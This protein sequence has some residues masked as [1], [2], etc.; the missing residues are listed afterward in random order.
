MS[1]LWDVSVIGKGKKWIDLEVV[2]AHPDAGNFPEDPAFALALLTHEA[3]GW[4]EHYNRVEKAPLS[5][6]I[7]FD[8]SYLPSSLN[9]IADRFIEKVQVYEA[10]N[11]PFDESEAHD[12]MD[13]KVLKEGIDRDDE[14]WDEAW[15]NHWADFW[16]DKKNLPWAKY[17]V[18]VTQEDWT[19]HLKVGKRFDTAS[20]SES[21][22]WVRENRKQAPDGE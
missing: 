6:E 16:A 13:Q 11:V 7:P 19:E 21:G 18:W 1:S 9:L 2:F 4:D 5:K 14:E 17:R 8:D 10:H 3:Y 22:P 15:E 20:F 12:K